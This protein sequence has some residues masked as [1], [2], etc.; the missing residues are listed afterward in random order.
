MRAFI[1]VSLW[2]LS[3]I[4]AAQ[5]NRENT[6]EAVRARVEN[7]KDSIASLKHA[8][9]DKIGGLQDTIDTLGDKIGGLQKTIGLNT[10]AI[11]TVVKITRD[12]NIQ[13]LHIKSEVQVE[14]KEHFGNPDNP[15]Q[16]TSFDLKVTMMEKTRTMTLS[17]HDQK[18][19][20]FF[21][22]LI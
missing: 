7:L 12:D 8:V 17:L 15:Q 13:K 22:A 14:L 19:D 6:T 18:K 1:F 2:A 21:S 4:S 20:I 9:E 3:L 16:V 11:S 5:Q 10:D